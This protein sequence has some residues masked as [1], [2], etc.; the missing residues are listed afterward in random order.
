MAAHFHAPAEA[1]TNAGVAIPITMTPSPLKGSATL[2][3]EQAAAL[4]SGKMYVNVHTDAHKGG[5]IRAQ[6]T[7]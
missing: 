4:T 3:D 1:G 7:P 5:E 2:T 6:L